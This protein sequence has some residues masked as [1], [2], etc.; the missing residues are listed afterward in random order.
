M[1]G[2][3]GLIELILVFAAVLGL[4]I[5]DLMATKRAIEAEP[6]PPQPAPKPK[7]PSKLRLAS[8]KPKPPAKLTPATH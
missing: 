5:W 1:S 8:A 7:A 2:Q 6:T 4:A 3:F